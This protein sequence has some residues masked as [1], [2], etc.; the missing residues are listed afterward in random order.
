MG[1]GDYVAKRVAFA[2]ITV[3]VA[4]TLNFVLFR[5]IPGDAVSALRCRQCT[6]AFKEFQRQE[7]GLD[8]SKWEQYRLYVADLAHGDLGR[9]LRTERSV[10][11]ELW[12][13]IRNTLPMI[14]LGT[15]FSILLGVA[16]GVVSAWRRGTAVD[17]GDARTRV[18][19]STRCRR[20]GSG[21]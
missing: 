12:G 2:L 5:A 3:L 1:R 19:A 11:S 6:A 10:S 14:A 18:S 16:A 13:P 17:R 7:L 9:S 15:F 8:K 21:S 4:I 20:S